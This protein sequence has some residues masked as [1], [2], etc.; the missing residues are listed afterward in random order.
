[1]ISTK[2]SEGGSQWVRGFIVGHAASIDPQSGVYV[3]VDVS[4]DVDVGVIIV[5]VSGCGL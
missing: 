1:M 4:V 3:D 2:S 5:H